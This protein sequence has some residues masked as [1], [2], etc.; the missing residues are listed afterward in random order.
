MWYW[1]L[2]FV[3][4]AASACVMAIEL[5]LASAASSRVRP[6]AA[7][8]TACAVALPLAIVAHNI[9]SV[10]LQGEEVVSFILALLVA[11]AGVMVGLLGAG[12]VLVRTHRSFGASVLL[13]GSGMALF[14]VYALFALV[15]SSATGSTPA[16]QTAIEPFVLLVAMA[17]IAGGTVGATRS[18]GVDAARH[19][20]R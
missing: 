17:A 4:A 11:P 19:P 14:A 7:L 16:F 6:W 18:R 20:S 12:A 5:W 15:F 2:F 9:L 13:M 1:P 10:V 3:V 8:T